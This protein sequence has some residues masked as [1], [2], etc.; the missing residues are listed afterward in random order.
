[1]QTGTSWEGNKLKFGREDQPIARKTS[2]KTIVGLSLLALFMSAFAG[3]ALATSAGA[4]TCSTLAFNPE[5][6][7]RDELAGEADLICNRKGTFKNLYMGVY[8]NINNFPDP[9]VCKKQLAKSR[10]NSISLRCRGHFANSG[11][12]YTYAEGA[13][14][15][16]YSSF[17]YFR[18]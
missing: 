8:R 2:L 7:D 17:K 13:G 6:I 12:F 14:G 1:M 3:L 4:V 16:D 15:R 5:R 11:Y 9:R 18:R 10:G